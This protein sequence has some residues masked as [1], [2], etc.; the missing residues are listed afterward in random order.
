MVVAPSNVKAPE[1][2][3]WDELPQSQKINFIPNYEMA[4]SLRTKSK[5]I[6]EVY[7]KEKEIEIDIF[8]LST[9]ICISFKKLK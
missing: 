2:L 4:G 7:L 1:D 8:Y 6:K 3:S 5:Q 9:I